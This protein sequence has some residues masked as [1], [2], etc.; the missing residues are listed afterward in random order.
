MSNKWLNRIVFW[1]LCNIPFA[2]LI[3]GAKS[4]AVDPL[5]IIVGIIVYSLYYRPFLH[6]IRLM[7]LRVIEE[8]DA[9]KLFIPFYHTRYIKPLW[10]G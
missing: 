8:K 10:L 9:W 3:L 6:I 5:V 1:A 7:K 4:K 2:L